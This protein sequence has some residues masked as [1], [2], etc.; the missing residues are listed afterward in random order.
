[1]RKARILLILGTWIVILSY[2]GFPQY[3]K[4]VLFVLSGLGLIYLS[5]TLYAEAKEKETSEKTFD[6]YKEN[7]FNENEMNSKEN[8]E[9]YKGVEA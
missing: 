6:N 9:E 3:L 1:M 2:L 8:E 4:D 7:N 5:Y